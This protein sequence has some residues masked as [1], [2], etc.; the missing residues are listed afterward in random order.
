MPSGGRRAWAGAV[1]AQPAHPAAARGRPTWGF[2]R[3][4]QPREGASLDTGSRPPGSVAVARG[5]GRHSQLRRAA[6]PDSRL[7]LCTGPRSADGA[8]SHAAGTSMWLTDTAIPRC[9]APWRPRSRS[10]PCTGA[11]PIAFL[12]RAPGHRGRA[13][14]RRPGVASSARRR[15]PRGERSPQVGA[16][17]LL[18]S[19]LHHAGF[20]AVRLSD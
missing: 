19:H 11:E 18:R 16:L 14:C 12:S 15:L 17:P 8:G 13:Q 6:S 1:A 7:W 9:S 10:L 20:W 5:P 4:Q 3:E 2:G